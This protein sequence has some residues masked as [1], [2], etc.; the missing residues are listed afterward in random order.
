[1]RYCKV[2]DFESYDL[3]LFATLWENT[4]LLRLL[5]GLLFWRFGRRNVRSRVIDLRH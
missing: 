4:L 5:L 3:L 2:L 1:M